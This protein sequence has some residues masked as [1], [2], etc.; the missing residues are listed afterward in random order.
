MKTETEYNGH[1][2]TPEWLDARFNWRKEA[3]E[4]LGNVNLGES[5]VLTNTRA[6]L[7]MSTLLSTP[8]FRGKFVSRKSEVGTRFTR[9]VK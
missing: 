9:F 1:K 5:F 2:E 8:K 4:F 6:I 3:T 7:N